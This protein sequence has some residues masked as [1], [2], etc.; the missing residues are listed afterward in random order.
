MVFAYAID[1]HVSITE[2]ASARSNLNK[3]IL[4]DLGLGSLEAK[5]DGRKVIS[6]LMLGADY[7]DNTIPVD[8]DWPSTW[9]RYRNHFYNPIN[10][11]GYDYSNP[12]VHLTGLPSPDW[13]LEDKGDIEGQQHSLKDAYEFLLEGLTLPTKAERDGKL[14]RLFQTLGH[15]VHLVQ[16]A[17][18]P[19]HTRNDS[20]ALGSLYEDY[21]AAQTKKGQLNFGDYPV[22]EL[23]TARSYFHTEEPSANNVLVGKG[24]AEYSNRGFITTGTN[25]EGEPGSIASNASFPTPNG[26]G[27]S[28]TTLSIRNEEFAPYI[29][30]GLDGDITFIG[31]NVPDTY[32]PSRSYFNSRTSTYSIFQPDLEAYLGG[33]PG[34]PFPP[35][36]QKAQFTF[37]T[38]NAREQQKLLIPRAVSY[39]AGLINWF[40]RGKI[41]MVKDPNNANQ[42]LIKNLG[43]EPLQ[44]TFTLYYDDVNDVRHDVPG[45]VWN[46][47]SLIADG[48]LAAGATITVPAFTP[49]ADAKIAYSYV[50]VFKGKI[51]ADITNP[52]ATDSLAAKLV[53]AAECPL[54]YVRWDNDLFMLSCNDAPNGTTRPSF[55]GTITI[56]GLTYTFVFSAG[57]Y[58]FLDFYIPGLNWGEDLGIKIPGYE[59]ST[60][61]SLLRVC[62][63]PS[64]FD[65]PTE[66]C[67]A[68]LALP[69]AVRDRWINSNF[70]DFGDPHVFIRYSN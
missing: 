10:G 58:N 45:A 7:E 32:A 42:Y 68:Q 9:A 63:D 13:G 41:D 65:P 54:S 33:S 44:G 39:S 17:A 27:V 37:N 64:S 55:E 38:I 47:A 24:M 60:E 62:N 6:W 19:Q 25:F 52:A 59:S 50:L 15:T 30:P 34:D 66:Y 5:I 31:T 43:T 48:H 12:F 35:A 46:T 3:G 11:Q 20:H 28:T 16:D 18:Q 2:E 40:F 14:S 22:V 49:P 23:P 56:Y 21:V 57:L 67:E 70:Q 36:V 61:I 69:P 8:P 53:L 26:S 1:T 51:G 4:R 29:A